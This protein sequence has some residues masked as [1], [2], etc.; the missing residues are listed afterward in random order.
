MWKNIKSNNVIELV[1]SFVGTRVKLKLA[2]HSK[3]L[4]KAFNI[5]LFNYKLFSGRFIIYD[6]NDIREEN[7]NI[8]YENGKEENERAKKNNITFEG[9][10]SNGKRKGPDKQN[11]SSNK[12]EDK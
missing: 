7:D 12:E 4:Q 10:I 8:N 9:E 5:N 3:I 2:K 6:N 11:N 1:F